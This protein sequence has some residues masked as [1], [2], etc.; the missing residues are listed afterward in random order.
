M[1]LSQRWMRASEWAKWYCNTVSRTCFYFDFVCLCSRYWVAPS[2]VLDCKFAVFGLFSWC[3]HPYR[4]G[5]GLY[6][7]HKNLNSG[8]HFMHGESTVMYWQRL[9]TEAFDLRREKFNL[10]G[11]RGMLVADAFTGNFSKKKA[12]GIIVCTVQYCTVLRCTVLQLKIP[13]AEIC[14]ICCDIQTEVN[15]VT[16]FV[17]LCHALYEHVWLRVLS[18]CLSRRVAFALEVGWRDECWASLLGSRRLVRPWPTSGR[19]DVSVAQLR[20]L[21]HV[22]RFQRQYRRICSLIADTVDFCRM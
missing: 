20:H 8:S 4:K 15:F 16:P 11:K 3:S 7:I 18:I 5:K 17:F 14:L 21:P 12:P 10:E 6:Y 19:V 9:L 22:Y 13:H 1:P 2:T